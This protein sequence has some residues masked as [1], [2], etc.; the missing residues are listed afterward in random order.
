M[1]FIF[2]GKR[3]ILL[4]RYCLS[5]KIFA[6]LINIHLYLHTHNHVSYFSELLPLVTTVI[7]VTV[8]K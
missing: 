1:L 6:P 3:D 2:L 4:D 8:L 7:Y 5:L